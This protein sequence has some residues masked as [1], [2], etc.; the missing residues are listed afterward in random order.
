[1]P[2]KQDVVYGLLV[3]LDDPKRLV[4]NTAVVARNLWFLIGTPIDGDK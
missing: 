4:R 2:F 3:P 1:M